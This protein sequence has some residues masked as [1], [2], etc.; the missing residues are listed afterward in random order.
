MSGVSRSVRTERTAARWTLS[1][2]VRRPKTRTLALGLE[3]KVAARV[4]S[5]YFRR[6]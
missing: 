5:E 1:V 4:R 6:K 3:R 2:P